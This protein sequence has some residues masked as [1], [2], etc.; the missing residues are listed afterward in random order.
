[1]RKALQLLVQN[2]TLILRAKNLLQWL[3]GAFEKAITFEGNGQFFQYILKHADVDDLSQ[4]Y[5]VQVY[6]QKCIKIFNLSI[7]LGF[8]G[9]LAQF[10]IVSEG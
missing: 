6:R 9:G 7:P 2:N 8:L 5:Q 10:Q 4:F 3:C 1:V